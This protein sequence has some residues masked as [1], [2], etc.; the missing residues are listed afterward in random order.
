MVMSIVSCWFKRTKESDVERG[1]YII[2]ENGKSIM[3]DS[4]A[5]KVP[6]P[7]R[8][9]SLTHEHFCTSIHFDEE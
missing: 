7:V 5:Q 2:G 1:L 9:Y 3:L 6:L 4:S 8:D